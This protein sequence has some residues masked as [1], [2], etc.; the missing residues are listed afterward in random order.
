MLSILI[1]D[2]DIGF[3]TFQSLQESLDSGGSLP[4]PDGVLINGQTHSTFTGDQGY[5]QII[6]ISFLKFC[7]FP[8][9]L[10]F[11]KQPNTYSSTSMFQVK[12]TCSGSQMWVCQHLLTSG[13]KDIK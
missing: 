3:F 12:L 13:F 4:L 11:P 5:C 7:T 2:V 10:K 6:S 1:S 8:F 9:S